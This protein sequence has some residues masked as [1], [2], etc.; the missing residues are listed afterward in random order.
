MTPL[1]AEVQQLA[2]DY[3]SGLFHFRSAADALHRAVQ[4][5][6]HPV[7]V[8]RVLAGAA[9]GS[10]AVQVHVPVNEDDDEY[11]AAVQDLLGR[12]VQVEPY[13]DPELLGVSSPSLAESVSAYISASRVDAFNELVRIGLSP[14]DAEAHVAGITPA[15]NRWDPSEYETRVIRSG[16]ESTV[17]W[18]HGRPTRI[19]V[20][21]APSFG[22]YGRPA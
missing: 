5:A 14:D 15:P 7:R 20:Q 2:R 16:T 10:V 9:F 4:D 22:A 1:Q 3:R 8:A 12:S 13:E 17:R 21:H 18:Q 19:D 6:G 11:C